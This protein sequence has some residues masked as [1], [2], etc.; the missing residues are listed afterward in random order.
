MGLPN[1]QM[2]WQGR[3]KAG[4]VMHRSQ[5][6][7]TATGST[8]AGAL[9][10]TG[11]LIELTTVAASTGVR[12]PQSDAGMDIMVINDGASTLTVYTALEE[13]GSPTIDGT[14][15]ATGVSHTKGST[16]RYKFPR[17]GVWYSK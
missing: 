14:A 8:Q 3:V 6:Q 15:G 1:I 5:S 9:Q 17:A 13:T 7:Q 12:L 4:H 2:I 10:I 16:K 11:D